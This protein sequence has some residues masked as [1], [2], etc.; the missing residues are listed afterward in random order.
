MKMFYDN[1][2][3]DDVAGLFS[4]WHFL[5]I[6][7]FICLVGLSLFLCRNM[8]RDRVHKLIFFTAIAMS[9][10]EILKIA[11]R[12]A[13]GSGVDSWI[14]LYYCSLFI[15]AVWLAI[16]KRTWISRTGSAVITMGGILSACLFT[17]YPS[18]SLALYPAWHPASLHSFFYH[19]VMAFVGILVLWKGV[20]V[21]QRR[22][23]LCYGVFVAAAC[24]VGY[25][26]N[27][28]TGSN[29]MFLHNAF[30]LPVLDGL[31]SFSHPLY[32]TVVCLAQSVLM[33]WANFGIYTLIRNRTEKRRK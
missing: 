22:D 6:L 21:P 4:G 7:L 29:C 3:E 13:K 25:F 24:F 27:E 9:A 33:F 23:S 19:F 20:F 2:T 32:M 5:F 30:K 16:S 1:F 8:T 17:L 18:T 11:I 12:I 10:V 14:P 31:L 15:Y 28:W 26:I